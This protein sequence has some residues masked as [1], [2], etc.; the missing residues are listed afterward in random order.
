MENTFWNLYI[1]QGVLK[2]K[3]SNV[4]KRYVMNWLIDP[5]NRLVKI[6][7]LA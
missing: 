1:P 7:T 6:K 5:D 3:C 2:K 4:M